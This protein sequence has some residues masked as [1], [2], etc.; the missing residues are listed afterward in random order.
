MFHRY[1]HMNTSKHTSKVSK[2]NT[3]SNSLKCTIPQQV[4]TSLDIANG[5]SIK[6]IIKE[7]NSNITVTIEKL[8]L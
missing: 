1:I 3:H 2:A 6:W 7:D 4:V 8:I 5:D